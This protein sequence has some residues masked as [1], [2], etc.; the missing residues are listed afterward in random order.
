MEANLEPP[1]SMPPVQVVAE[2]LVERP[3]DDGCSGRLLLEQA[4]VA[5]QGLLVE[6]AAV[7]ERD[8]ARRSRL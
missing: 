6:P 3:W 4:A 1:L 2:L 7:S 5:I 8:E